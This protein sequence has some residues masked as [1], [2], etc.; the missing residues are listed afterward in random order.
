MTTLFSLG[1]AYAVM[2][3]DCTIIHTQTFNIPANLTES[4]RERIA[5]LKLFV[6]TDFG[7]NWTRV[8]TKS[9]GNSNLFAFTA[10]KSGIYWFAVQSIDKDGTAHPPRISDLEAGQKVLVASYGAL[11]PQFVG[12][13]KS[14]DIVRLEKEIAKLQLELAR[15]ERE[16]D[17]K[18]SQIYLR[19]SIDGKVISVVVPLSP[20]RFP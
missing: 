13:K 8:E 17:S 12:R 15:K 2:L 16:A 1:V 3:S 9:V 18:R 6:S 14:E 20:L 7:S 5:Y 19:H 10:S 11:G 4:A